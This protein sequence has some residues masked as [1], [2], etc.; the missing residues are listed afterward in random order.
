MGTLYDIV[1]TVQCILIEVWHAHAQA[2]IALYEYGID[3]TTH[4]LLGQLPLSLSYVSTNV[5][6]L[7]P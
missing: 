4:T 2:M 5:P 6:L 3:Y 1:S 7:G